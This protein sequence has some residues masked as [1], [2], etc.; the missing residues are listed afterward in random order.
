MN[1]SKSLKFTLIAS[2]IIG[3]YVGVEILFFPVSFY[4]TSGI[5]LG[6]N[7]SLLNEIRAPGGALLLCSVLIISGAFI[8]KLSFTSI[9]LATLLYLSYGLSRIVSMVVDGKPDEILV[10]VAV[11][12]IVIGLFCAFMLVKYLKYED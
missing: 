11:L 9:V 1:I 8:P 12:E 7:V 2:G 3:L 10:Y 5:E 4:A 6:G